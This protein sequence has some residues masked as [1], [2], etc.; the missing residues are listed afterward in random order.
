MQAEGNRFDAPL[1]DEEGRFG[2]EQN[3][4]VDVFIELGAELSEGTMKRTF[5][6]QT[7]FPTGSKECITFLSFQPDQGRQSC[8]PQ[9]SIV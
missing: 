4:I 3:T 2:Y 6:T 1:S 5:F 7:M 9:P 8:L